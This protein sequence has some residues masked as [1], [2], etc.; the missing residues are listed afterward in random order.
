MTEIRDHLGNTYKTRTEM[1]KRYGISLPCFEYRLKA[2]WGLE[3]ALCTKSSRFDTCCM[4]H[5]GNVYESE[6]AMCKAYGIGHTTYRQRIEHNW[7]LLNRRL[8]YRKAL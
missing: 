5:L 1:C 8:C 4:D 2:N 7:G 6:K 3:R